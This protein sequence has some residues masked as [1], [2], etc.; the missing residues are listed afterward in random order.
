MDREKQSLD[1]P[2]HQELDVTEMDKVVGGSIDD[3]Q[4]GGDGW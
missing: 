3:S 4:S 2:A 1:H